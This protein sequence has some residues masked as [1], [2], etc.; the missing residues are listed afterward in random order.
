M[1]IKQRIIDSILAVEG[2]FVDDPSDSGGETNWGITKTVARAEGYEGPMATM[3][4]AVAVSI[5]ERQYWDAIHG[6]TLVKM[7][8]RVAEEVAEAGV[9]MGVHRAVT[10]LQ[11][12]LNVLNSGGRLY[13]EMPVDGILGGQTL[14]C[15]GEYLACRDES[16]LVTMLNVLQG[17]HYIEL[18][19]RREKDERFI[20]GWVRNRVAL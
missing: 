17:S 10:I 13:C 16:V 2:G 1:T 20:Y 15:L 7:S 8:E 9:H 18:A 3:P 12:C 6:D 11:R 4:R 5:Y 14:R 19:E